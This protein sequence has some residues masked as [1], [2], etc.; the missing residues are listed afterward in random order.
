VLL[1]I[2]IEAL[3]AIGNEVAEN[4]DVCGHRAN[5]FAG[6]GVR[7]NHQAMFWQ[8]EAEE[9]CLGVSMS[10][11]RGVVEFRIRATDHVVFS[12]DYRSRLPAFMGLPCSFATPL[13]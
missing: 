9:V 2:D 10:R 13:K 6:H 1:G 12:S 4:N 3:G 7:R 8:G 5:P 11:I